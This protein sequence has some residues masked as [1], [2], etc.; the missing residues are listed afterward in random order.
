M[1]SQYV[2]QYRVV[3]I[4]VKYYNVMV[5]IVK[6]VFKVIKFKVINKLVKPIN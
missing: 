4:Q 1:S 5:I 6:T 2:F 3:C